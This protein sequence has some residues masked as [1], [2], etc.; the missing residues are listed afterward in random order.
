MHQ[1]L[2]IRD[3]IFFLIVIHSAND[4]MENTDLLIRENRLSN[5]LG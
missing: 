2:H 3:A 4:V 5:W 1:L